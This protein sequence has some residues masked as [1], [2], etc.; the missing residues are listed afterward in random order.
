MKVKRQKTNRVEG[1]NEEVFIRL[2][3]VPLD[4]LRYN[5]SMQSGSE[6]KE[7][8]KSL[9]LK[10]GAKKPKNAYINYK[11]LM[12]NKAKAKREAEMCTV[13]PYANFV[14]KTL[15]LKQT[16]KKGKNKGRDKLKKK[17]S[18]YRRRR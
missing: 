3:D 5:I 15:P 4:I 17:I 13:D 16:R 18:K 8:R 9:L 6:R 14:N 12:Q 11:E 7:T 1:D 10:M 2:G